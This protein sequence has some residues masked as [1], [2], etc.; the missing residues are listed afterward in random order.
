M[1]ALTRSSLW[2]WI[3]TDAASRWALF[4][5]VI[6]LGML[7]ITATLVRE[8]TPNAKT[9]GTLLV[10]AGICIL[11]MRVLHFRRTRSK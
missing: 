7:V 11:V 10:I 2:R 6:G 1:I 4:G 5:L 9:I 8:A 3:C